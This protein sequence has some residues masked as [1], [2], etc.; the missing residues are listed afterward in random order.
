MASRSKL[1]PITT[2]TAK[3]HARRL[4][5]RNLVIDCAIG[6]HPH[7]RGRTQRVALDVTLDIAE[8][9]APHGDHIAEVVSYDDVIAGIRAIVAEGHINLVESLAERVADMCLADSRVAS[10]NVRVE[11]LDVLGDEAVVGIEIER[12][13]AD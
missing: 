2:P 7:E 9:N 13:C 5:V 11:K 3:S 10:V 1:H 6:I 4:F 12:S 8:P